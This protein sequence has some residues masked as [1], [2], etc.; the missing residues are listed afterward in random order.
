MGTDV[1]DKFYQKKNR[2]RKLFTL[3]DSADPARSAVMLERKDKAARFGVFSIPC[4]SWF[5]TVRSPSSELRQMGELNSRNRP[6]IT[7]S[8]RRLLS[9]STSNFFVHFQQIPRWNPSAQ[10]LKEHIR[11]NNT[12]N[13]VTKIIRTRSSSF[14]MLLENER[15]TD[16][17]N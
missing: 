10:V 15:W 5:R 11:K 17:Q 8:R 9:Y 16:A 12:N 14:W 13:N 6:L 1:G 4:I 3:R 2:S 7:Q